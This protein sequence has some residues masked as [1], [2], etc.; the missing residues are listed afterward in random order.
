MKRL[1]P[2]QY[3]LFVD[4]P[5]STGGRYLTYR[6]LNMSSQTPCPYG[7]TADMPVCSIKNAPVHIGSFLCTYCPYYDKSNG[8]NPEGNPILCNRTAKDTMTHFIAK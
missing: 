8:Y 1:D 3:D 2:R 6:I 5:A 4:T 7:M